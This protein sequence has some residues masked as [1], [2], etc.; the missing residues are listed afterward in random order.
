[1]SRLYTKE[2]EICNDCD[3]GDYVD[4]AFVCFNSQDKDGNDMIVIESGDTSVDHSNIR[5]PSWCKLKK[6]RSKK[7]KRR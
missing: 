5:I 1:M 3:N 4:G 7:K 2:V 6:I